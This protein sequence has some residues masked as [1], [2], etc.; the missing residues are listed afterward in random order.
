MF[1]MEKAGRLPKLPKDQVRPKIVTGLEALGRSTDLQ[2]LNT[3]IQQIAPFGES[4]LGTL[5]IGEYIKRIGSSLGV[6][7]NGLIKSD[8]Q[9]AQEAQLAQ[10]QALQAQVAPQVAKEGM[11]MV[12]DSVKETQRNNNQEN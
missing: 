10:E 9:L 11:G 3:F 8:E 4:G 12:R 5:N 1:Q 2:R 6:D 7:M